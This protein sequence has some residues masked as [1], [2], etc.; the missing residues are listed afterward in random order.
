M[1][2]R[3]R[4]I[5]LLL[6]LGLIA[7]MQMEFLAFRKSDRKQAQYLLERGQEAPTFH[8]YEID[9]RTIHYTHVG[10][11]G[12]PLLVLIHGAPGSS[13][14]FMDYL[15][16][17][18]LTQFVQLI[19]VDRPGYGWSDYGRAERSVQAQAAQLQPLLVR[20]EASQTLLLGHSYG[21]P[22]IARMAMD[23]PEQVNG[24]IIVAGSVDPE[25]E[26]HEWW[27]K[28]ADTPPVRWILP[29]SMKVCNQEILPLRDELTEMLPL[30]E[31]VRCPV[32]IVQ[33]VKDKLVPAGNADFAE[34]ALVNS[35]RVEKHLLEDG[36]HFI[37]W[38]RR[39]EIRE[40]IRNLVN[41]NDRA[42]E[43]AE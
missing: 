20:H 32:T 2:L 31:K 40:M 4:H 38:T 17:T 16:D 33:G 41:F 27:R 9:G 22:V 3:K 28:P 6:P 8:T 1:K 29:G 5:I 24:L 13:S 34:Q 11:E 7:A 15:A 39:S 10:D 35:E 26:P 36:N 18:V 25:L 21:G 14:A 12:K 23:Y 43:A 37:L 30:W 19:A 42:R